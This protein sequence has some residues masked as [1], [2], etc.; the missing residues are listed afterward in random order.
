[1]LKRTSLRRFGYQSH[2]VVH[3]QSIGYSPFG[4]NYM[5][6][7][8][9][10]APWRV[11]RTMTKP[12]FDPNYRIP[13]YLPGVHVSM[14]DMPA[15]M[16]VALKPW[17]DKLALGRTLPATD[18]ADAIAD[19]RR[20]AP[21]IDDGRTLRVWAAKVMQLGAMKGSA[22]ADA[23]FELVWKG[24]V[25]GEDEALAKELRPVMF[26]DSSGGSK[27]KL[28]LE[29]DFVV[30]LL[31]CAAQSSLVDAALFAEVFKLATSPES[32]WHT[33]PHR[34]STRLWECLLRRC[35]QKG[36]EQGVLL[37]LREMVD[38]RFDF[39]VLNTRAL[40]WGL[41]AVKSDEGYAEVKKLLFH[42]TPEKTL[43]LA[44]QYTRQRRIAEE[45]GDEEPAAPADDGEEQKHKDIVGGSNNTSA[46]GSPR[47]LGY[48]FPVVP[49][50]ERI[51]TDNDKMYYHVSWHN[52]L[53]RPLEFF[54][55]RLYFDYKPS[56]TGGDTRN[57]NREARRQ[58]KDIIAEKIAA[59]KEEGLLPED[60][61]D[62]GIRFH[63]R[64]AA[65]KA[66]LRQ[67]TWKKKPNFL[68]KPE[69]GEGM[70]SGVGAKS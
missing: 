49:K 35:G 37:T 65:F 18:P 16:Q 41:N 10:T 61:D 51:P 64:S 30:A 36:D 15:T 63:N 34:F 33:T 55:R 7:Q 42:L 8:N 66:A 70:F 56:M 46:G 14:E 53:R 69:Y 13:K 38:H 50:S 26:P 67:E 4:W 60:Y 44:K 27:K 32:V 29:H 17:L 2:D 22:G 52:R 11:N 6:P 54:P 1:M 45:Q 20:I 23:A 12:F 21:R 58:I 19:F 47:S 25:K 24:I 9:M 31:Y 62:S 39:D 28:A 43:K 48:R 68:K 40:V 59:W 5:L 57:N 3:D